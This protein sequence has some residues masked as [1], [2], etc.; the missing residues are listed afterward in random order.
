MHL[1]EQDKK[2][3]FHIVDKERY[4]WGNKAGKWL[5]RVVKE[6]KCLSFIPKIKN[7]DGEMVHSSP[8]ICEG[9]PCIL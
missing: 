6:K 3:A 1:L 5:A 4:Q 9:I 7:D 2:H 8:E